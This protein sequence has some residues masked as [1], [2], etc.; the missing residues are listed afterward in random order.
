[1]LTR[2]KNELKSV[3]LKYSMRNERCFVEFCGV[4]R[5]MVA[6]VVSFRSKVMSRWLGWNGGVARMEA[7]WTVL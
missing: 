6:I 1:M 3:V 2:C 5:D 4:V 7:V